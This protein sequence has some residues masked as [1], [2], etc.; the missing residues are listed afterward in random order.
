M[1]RKFYY[2]YAPGHDMISKSFQLANAILILSK[3][4]TYVMST[5]LTVFPMKYGPPAELIALCRNRSLPEVRA[6]LANYVE[7]RASCGWHKKAMDLWY[8][9][10]N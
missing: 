1:L 7:H 4:R 10:A 6:V 9:S 8:S 5:R 3:K 2:G